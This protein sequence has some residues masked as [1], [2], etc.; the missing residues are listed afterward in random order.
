MEQGL[1][2]VE[3]LESEKNKGHRKDAAY[4]N[5]NDAR[6]SFFHFNSS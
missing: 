3:G 1:M 4:S 2:S 5:F 6:A